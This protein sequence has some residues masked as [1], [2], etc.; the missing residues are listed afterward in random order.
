[1]SSLA[2]YL[3]GD[4]WLICT[5]NVGAYAPNSLFPRLS[6]RSTVVSVSGIRLITGVCRPL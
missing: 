1:M 4:F 2:I 3:T 6:L 5:T